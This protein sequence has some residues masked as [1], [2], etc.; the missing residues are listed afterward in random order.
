MQ[1]K[2]EELLRAYLAD[3][4]RESRLIVDVL[5]SLAVGASHRQEMIDE[6][7]AAVTKIKS[8][9][10]RQDVSDKSSANESLHNVTRR[11]HVAG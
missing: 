2:F 10:G 4:D 7:D 1:D 9:S 3:K 5:S 6:I 8:G 11:L